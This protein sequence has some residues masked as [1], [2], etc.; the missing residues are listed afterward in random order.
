MITA[1]CKDC[2]RKGCGSYHDKCP[3]YQ[4]YKTATKKESEEKKKRLKC[5]IDYK[6][7]AIENCIKRNRDRTRL[8]QR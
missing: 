1:P 3:E 5:E 6:T 7:M 8:K 4:E 2:P